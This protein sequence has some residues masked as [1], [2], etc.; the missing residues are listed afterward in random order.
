MITSFSLFAV[1]KCLKRAGW[2]A[3]LL[4]AALAFAP[5]SPSFGGVVYTGTSVVASGTTSGGHAARATF[6]SG[7]GGV[8]RLLLENTSSSPTMSPSELLTSVYFNVLTGTMTG[9]SAPLTYQSASG[10]VYLALRTMTDKAATY[11][12]PPPPGGTVTY[13][14]IPTP[15]NLQ[16]F[17]PGDNT[18][19]FKSGMS[20]VASEPPLAF[21]VGTVGNSAL[22]PNNFNGNIVNGFDFGIY[23]GDVTTQNLNN[24]LLVKDAATFEFAGFGGFD[25]SQVSPHVVFGFGTGPDCIVSV[26]EPGTLSLAAFGLLAA[27]LTM[28]PRRGPGPRRQVSRA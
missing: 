13:P 28:R 4:V 14:A 20:L 9:S 27:I 12:P 17:N 6:T 21:G 25:L 16:A 1:F 11:A 23:V 2:P 3:L 7:T 19:Q 10:Q 5:A 18:W 24:T 15:S 26:P 22:T 8:L